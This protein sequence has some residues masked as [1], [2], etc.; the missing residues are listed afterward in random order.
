MFTESVKPYAPSCDENKKV[1]LEA[2]KPYLEKKST[3]LEI[4]SGTGQ[5][6]AYFAQNMSHL[7]WQTSDLKA[8]KVGISM[9][10]KEA[11]LPNL[12]YPI[13][14]N[15]SESEWPQQKFDAIFTANSLHIMSQKNVKDMFFKL[16][17]V[18]DKNGLLIVYGPFNYGGQ[19]T[20]Q[21]NAQ[22]DVWLKN[23][24]RLSCIKDFEWCNELAEQ[25][26]LHL[27]KDIEMPCNNRVLIW[28]R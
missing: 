8:A 15:V 2:I 14:L 1:I 10:L 25:A 4:A 28:Q 17:Q 13:E 12:L 23:Q 24:N 11:D 27:L 3:V 18:L 21:S 7:K 20:S 22:F 16:T 19:Y 9:W 5:H 6:A 26:Q